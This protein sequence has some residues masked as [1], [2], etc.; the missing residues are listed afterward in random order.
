MLE[1]IERDDPPPPTNVPTIAAGTL[2]PPGQIVFPFTELVRPRS[3]HVAYAFDFGPNW[4]NGILDYQPPRPAPPY[5]IRVPGTDRFGN[6]AT[7]IR[8]LELRVPIGTFA[9]FALRTGA[10]FATDEM[11]G[12]LGSFAPLAARDEDRRQ[13]D[14]R[15]SFA[16]LYPTLEAYQAQ[17]DRA[18][19]ELIA[20]GFLLPRDRAAAAAAA[21]AR[22]RWM[23]G[24]R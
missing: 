15:P 6:E 9:P 4:K 17:V 10:P 22:H 14:R 1:W 19:D 3:P 12:Y 2:V 23:T 20:E 13:G 21:L 5:A 7:G 18:L 11:V 24:P 16:R 8:P